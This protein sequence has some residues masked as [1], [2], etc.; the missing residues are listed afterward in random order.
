MMVPSK[1]VAVMDRA[2]SAVGSEADGSQRG[3]FAFAAWKG[4]QAE[5][6]YQ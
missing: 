1:L 2:P 3:S 4:S 6:G 5:R